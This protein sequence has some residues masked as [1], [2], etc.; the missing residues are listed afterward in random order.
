MSAVE[1]HETGNPVFP[2]NVVS[3]CMSIAE[4]QAKAARCAEVA[5]AGFIPYPTAEQARE[6]TA[7][8]LEHADGAFTGS[9][10]S[11]ILIVP[12]ETPELTPEQAALQARAEADDPSLG[13]NVETVGKGA[14]E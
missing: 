2:Y 7:W 6:L 4:A 14:E 9:G 5:H 11:Q 12:R 8:E 13:L 1:I 3:P 10:S